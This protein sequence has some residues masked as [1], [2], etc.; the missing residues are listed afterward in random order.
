MCTAGGIGFGEETQGT[1]PRIHA[2]ITQV[3]RVIIRKTMAKKRLKQI[4]VLSFTNKENQITNEGFISQYAAK[5]RKYALEVTGKYNQLSLTNVPIVDNNV[6]VD[7]V[8]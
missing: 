8:S 7:H 6:E 5:N 1:E 2:T 3:K 4:Y